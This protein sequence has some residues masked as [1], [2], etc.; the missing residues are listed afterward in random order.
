VKNFRAIARSAKSVTLKANEP[1]PYD[2]VVEGGR[3]IDPE[4]ELDGV[5]YVGITGDRGHWRLDAL[6]S[7]ASLSPS[8]PIADR[9]SPYVC[10]TAQWSLVS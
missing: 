5:R 1:R 9:P 4:T 3:V 8:P 6:A 7:V 2:L 10:I